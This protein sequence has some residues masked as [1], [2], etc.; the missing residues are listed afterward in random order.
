MKLFYYDLETTGVNH[1]QHSIHQIAGII[2][3][4][5]VEQE[6]FE[7]NL[8]PN[9]KARIEDEALEV[10]NKTK[11]EVLNNPYTF[12]EAYQ[13]LTSILTQYVDKYNKKDKFFTVGYNNSSFDDKFLKAFFIQN[14]D[15]YYGSLFWSHAIDVMVLASAHFVDIRPEMVN[16]QLR[17]VAAQCGIEIEEEKLHDAVYDIEL[18]REILRIVKPLN[19]RIQ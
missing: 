16:F 17:T 1:W 7:I 10:A 12:N 8:Q 3:I 5:G 4:D 11:E 14:N 19:W 6:R 18:T 13:K 2:E 9:P 15:K